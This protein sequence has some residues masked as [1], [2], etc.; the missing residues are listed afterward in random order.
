MGC[1]KCGK[2]DLLSVVRHSDLTIGFWFD[3]ET[4][5]SLQTAGLVRL[6]NSYP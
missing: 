4:A 2:R 1:H 3:A 6:K 5:F